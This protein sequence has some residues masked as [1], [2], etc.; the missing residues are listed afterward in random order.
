MLST[1]MN[2]LKRIIENI[3]KI[4]SKQIK[5]FCPLLVKMIVGNI[6]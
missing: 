4:I 3:A 2:T 1:T 6:L 5:Q